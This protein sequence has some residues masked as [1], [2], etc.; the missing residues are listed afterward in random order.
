MN[1]Q[2]KIAQWYSI[3]CKIKR[4]EEPEKKKPKAE[5]N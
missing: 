1:F 2:A 3:N 5:T 4:K